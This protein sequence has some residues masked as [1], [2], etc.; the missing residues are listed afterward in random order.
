MASPPSKGGILGASM[1]WDG[2]SLGT[3]ADEALCLVV[4]LIEGTGR[5]P[6]VR[7]MSEMEGEPR[8]HGRKGLGIES[9][10]W[11]ARGAR[12]RMERDEVARWQR[13]MRDLE[14]V[15]CLRN[16]EARDRGVLKRNGRQP[17]IFARAS[18][19][20]HNVRNSFAGAKW[21]HRPLRVSHSVRNS[22]GCEKFFAWSAKIS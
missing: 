4:R 22:V 16:E 7:A 19:V 13:K 6:Q 1:A 11:D 8:V 15:W 5:A 18:W 12:Y 2:E 14:G 9:L 3:S 10:K 20:S 17:F 21:F